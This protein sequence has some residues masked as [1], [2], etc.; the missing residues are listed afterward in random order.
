MVLERVLWRS[1]WILLA[2][3]LGTTSSWAQ[4]TNVTIFPDSLGVAHIDAERDLDELSD[5][6]QPNQPNP[7]A[8][9]SFFDPDNPDAAQYVPF[10]GV[11]T[12]YPDQ[13]VNAVLHIASFDTNAILEDTITASTL[14]CKFSVENQPG[15][16]TEFYAGTGAVRYD[17]GGGFLNTTITPVG[18]PADIDRVA[19][20]DLLAAGVSSIAQHEA[21]EIDFVNNSQ[22]NL[23]PNFGPPN[24]V[25]F[26]SIRI[27][28]TYTETTPMDVT[29]VTVD[30]FTADM[31]RS[32]E[33]VILH[34]V[35][36]ANGA[37]SRNSLT[38]LTVQLG[39]NSA[40][41][42][43]PNGVKLYY[44]GGTDFID[45]D[46]AIPIQSQSPAASVTFSGLAGTT[47]NHRTNHFWISFTPSATAG[48]DALQHAYINLAT[49][50]TFSPPDPVYTFSG[51]SATPSPASARTLRIFASDADF[52]AHGMVLGAGQPRASGTGKVSQTDWQRGKPLFEQGAVLDDN[53]P[54]GP[55]FVFG[56]DIA[57]EY[58]IQQDIVLT[59][60]TIDLSGFQSADL[61]FY[62]ST[63]FESDQF[64]PAA[65]GTRD[66]YIVQLSFDGVVFNDITFPSADAVITPE[67]DCGATHSPAASCTPSGG[68]PVGCPTE[69]FIHPDFL[70]PLSAEPGFSCPIDDAGRQAFM[71]EHPNVFFE[72]FSGWEQVSVQIPS[73]SIYL[74]ADFKFR[75][76]MGT[77]T[78]EAVTDEEGVLIDDV[79]VVGVSVAEAPAVPA[80]GPRALG[81]LAVLLVAGSAAVLRMRSRLSAPTGD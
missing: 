9:T 5:P 64:L 45:L 60:P 50:L 37:L 63:G 69:C 27:D 35:V 55:G 41:V 43:T 12:V 48:N 59:S 42:L 65:F 24:G 31:G 14:R 10:D 46:S 25:S 17:N 47:L 20:F 6:D 52:S 4:S 76:R 21:L 23:P 70:N 71:R 8:T 22:N 28:V 44:T 30:Q 13:G 75:I 32:S 19:T 56:T 78:S 29:D 72:G 53:S 66:G 49:D 58:F 51:G 68:C 79:V 16:P 38:D 18:I 67:Y 2:L 62:H 77:D 81:V 74:T 80:L 15:R 54:Q 36:Q 33:H 3:L 40:D 1:T 61:S 26:D 57:N 34:M 73:G 11:L 7:D 39:G